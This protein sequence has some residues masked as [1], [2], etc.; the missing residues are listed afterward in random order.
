[1]KKKTTIGPCCFG[2]HEFENWPDLIEEGEKCLCGA[3][4]AHWK[5]CDKCGG[6]TL[7]IKLKEKDGIA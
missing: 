2:L 7:T 5:I 4:V 1:M 3:C 6:R